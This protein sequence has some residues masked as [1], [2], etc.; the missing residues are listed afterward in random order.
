M[1]IF[2]EFQEA[3][4]LEP[5]YI[6]ETDSDGEDRPYWFVEDCPEGDCRKNKHWQ[7]KVWRCRSYVNEE[8]SKLYLTYHLMCCDQHKKTREAAAEMADRIE[9][10]TGVETSEERKGYRGN[11]ANCRNE[12]KK[13]PRRGQLQSSQ[14]QG[15]HVMTE[16]SIAAVANRAVAKAVAAVQSGT[17]SAP[18][19]AASETVSNVLAV[20][21]PVHV[22][23]PVAQVEQLRDIIQRAASSCEAASTACESLRRKF[24]DEQR[25]L[26]QATNSLD[27]LV[28]N[29]R[30]V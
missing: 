3:Q 13:K 4:R 11:V 28:I 24:D 1:T 17:S 14:G 18:I 2:D 20:A 16:Q 19:A 9:V 25:I 15:G 26:S 21:T 29:L 7:S 27:R 22:N 6:D 10:Q 23:M 30:T 5:F 12:G 8:A